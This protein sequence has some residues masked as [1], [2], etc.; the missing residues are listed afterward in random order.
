MKKIEA[1]VNQVL[2]YYKSQEEA[3]KHIHLDELKDNV[4]SQLFRKRLIRCSKK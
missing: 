4:A 3:E 1:Q 2:K